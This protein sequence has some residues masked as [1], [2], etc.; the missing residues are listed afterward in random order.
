VVAGSVPSAQQPL[1]SVLDGL[2]RYE[3]LAGEAMYLDG[4]GSGQP[5]RPQA[6]ALIL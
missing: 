1:R 6:A 5:G 3:A 2:G 4:Q